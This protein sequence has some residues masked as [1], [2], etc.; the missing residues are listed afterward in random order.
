MTPENQTA[1]LEPCK[2]LADRDV[3]LDTYFVYPYKSNGKEK[4]Y[5]KPLPKHDEL[6]INV[7]PAPT[8]A[9]L[10][11]VLPCRTK[12]FRTKTMGYWCHTQEC[13]D[14]IPIHLIRNKK[15]LADALCAMLNWLIDEGIVSVEEIN[16]MSMGHPETEQLMKPVREALDKS[17]VPWPSDEWTAIWNRSYEVVD[18]L[19]TKLKAHG[20][21]VE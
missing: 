11:A 6:A 16:R 4:R 19:V 15:T 21:P 12:S 7:I 17:G 8:A 9:E 18:R 1:S 3:R 10:I 2:E 14:P 13:D 20:I 5:G